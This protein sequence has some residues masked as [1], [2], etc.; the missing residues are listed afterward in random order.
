M[1]RGE[2]SD[3]TPDVARGRGS[4]CVAGNEPGR[5]EIVRYSEENNHGETHARW[6]FVAGGVP[7]AQIASRGTAANVH[8]RAEDAAQQSN[9]RHGRRNQGP[10][11]ATPVLGGH[12][13]RSEQTLESVGGHNNSR[14]HAQTSKATDGDP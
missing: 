8:S 13:T 2:E 1:E 6:I 12:S 10:T 3:K 4:G 11:L 7:Q 14:K 9:A 5:P